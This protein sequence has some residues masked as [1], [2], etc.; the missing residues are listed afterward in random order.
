MPLD[1][2]RDPYSRSRDANGVIDLADAWLRRYPDV[3]LTDRGKEFLACCTQL[4]TPIRSRQSAGIFL[5]TLFAFGRAS[6]PSPL[7]DF[8][9]PSAG[10]QPD[11]GDS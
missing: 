5:A 6:N 7:Q 2:R 1:D 9:A 10:S 11:G 8:G 3:D 4:E